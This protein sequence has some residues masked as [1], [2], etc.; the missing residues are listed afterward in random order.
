MSLNTRPSRFVFESDIDA[1]SS[2][3]DGIHLQSELPAVF[4]NA[5]G[6]LRNIVIL[7]PP[8]GFHDRGMDLIPLL[9]SDAVNNTDQVTLTLHRISVIMDPGQNA[10][11]RAYR[12]EKLYTITAMIASSQIY[13]AGDLHDTNAY[14]G[15]DTIPAAVLTA[16][17]TQLEAK[18]GANLSVHSPADNTP[19]VIS[20]PDL[21]GAWALGIEAEITAGAG[22]FNVLA[23]VKT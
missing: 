22:K 23:E 17:A 13:A 20:I 7:G 1:V 10:N 14:N 5:A 8:D 16:R 3:T 11:V 15:I 19:G 12:T 6:D 18:V 2:L 21:D 9:N 4:L